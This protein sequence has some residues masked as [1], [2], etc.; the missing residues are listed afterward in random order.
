MIDKK[1]EIFK[2]GKE[3][4]EATGFKNTNVSQIMKKSGMA[5]GTFYNYY[6]SK[7]KLFMDIFLEENVKL[8]K[9]II[10]KVDV[11]KNPLQVMQK[12]MYLNMKGMTENRILR[13]WYNKE[14]YNKIEKAYQKEKGIERVDF[15]YDAFIEVVK[16][17]QDNGKMRTDIS[18][19][20]IM[21]IFG[22]LINVDAH[23][24]EI[25]IEY[26][27]DVINYLSKFTMDGLICFSNE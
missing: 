4:F 2:Y 18:P 21:A 12:M 22:A 8:K 27:P 16:K 19:E 5:T 6:S 3:L 14:I 7:D 20:M 9:D 26:F 25:G 13:E 24:E 23:K 15:M 17:W 1:K 11:N 10:A